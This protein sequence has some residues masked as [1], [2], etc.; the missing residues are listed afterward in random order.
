MGS[1]LWE[2]SRTGPEKLSIHCF[3]KE[4]PS[5]EL[6]EKAVSEKRGDRLRATRDRVRQPPWTQVILHEPDSQAPKPEP[7]LSLG[8]RGLTAGAGPKSHPAPGG[9]LLQCLPMAAGLLAANGILQ[10]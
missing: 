8:R 5:N 9:V 7:R 6:H 3:Q 1:R 4:D 10:A 2:A